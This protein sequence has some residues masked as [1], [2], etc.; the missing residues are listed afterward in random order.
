[1]CLDFGVHLSIYSDGGTINLFSTIVVKSI[2]RGDDPATNDPDVLAQVNSLG[3]NLIGN[4]IRATGINDGTNHDQVGTDTAP[5]NP[6]LTGLADNGG[7]TLTMAIQNTGSLAY[8]KGNCGGYSGGGI[9]IPPVAD[10]QRGYQ[11]KTGCDTGAFEYQAEPIGAS[12]A[13][14]T[15]TN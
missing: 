1:L 7:P 10:D 15:K 9:L 12:S 13:A 6:N 5:K 3:Y 2:I 14:A 8:Q 4:G 11:R